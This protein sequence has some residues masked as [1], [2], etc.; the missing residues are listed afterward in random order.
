[1]RTK[2]TLKSKISDLAIYHLLFHRELNK[3]LNN[4]CIAYKRYRY[5]AIIFILGIFT[6]P[7]ELIAQNKVSYAYSS[8]RTCEIVSHSSELNNCKT[9]Q[10]NSIITIDYD[11]KSIVILIDNK[12]RINLNIEKVLKMSD[13]FHIDCS[14]LKGSDVIIEVYDNDQIWLK[15]RTHLI[16]YQSPYEIY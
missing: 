8:L 7:C 2:D 12:N 5:F 15:N 4:A 14:D 3:L 9:L 6:S 1:M 11:N 10:N 13:G 16:V